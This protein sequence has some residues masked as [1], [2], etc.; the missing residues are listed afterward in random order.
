MAAYPDNP[1]I[2][3]GEVIYGETFPNLGSRLGSRV[4]QEFVQD[5]SAG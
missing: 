1:V 4:K 5:S 3:E 2:V